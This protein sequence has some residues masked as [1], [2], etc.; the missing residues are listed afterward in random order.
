LFW[1]LGVA[2]MVV[3]AAV[4]I[5][6]G[7]YAFT[8]IRTFHHDR[9]FAELKQ[10]TDLARSSLVDVVTDD[11]SA[12]L[13]GAVATNARAA[14][15]R[16][17]VVRADGYVLADSERDPGSMDDHRNRPEIDAALRRGTGSAVRHSDTLG[18]DMLYVARRLDD[19]EPP[20]AVVRIARPRQAV[21]A[22]L[23]GLLRGVGLAGVLSLTLTLLVIILVSRSVTRTVA[24]VAEGA[25]RVAGGDLEHR[26]ERPRTREL[27]VLVDALNRLT[28]QF[29]EQIT[30][31]DTQ[32]AEQR[33]ILQSMSNGMIALD[34]D[35]RVLTVNRVAARLLGLAADPARGRL[36]QE[37][38]REPELNRFVERALKA[39]APTRDELALTSGT[40]RLIEAASEPLLDAD[41][42][43]IG[44]VILINDVTQL[45]R[46]ESMRSDFA[47]NV[48][49]ELRT[50]ITNIKGYVE[51]MLEVGFE[52]AP[53]AR[54][55]LEV[56]GRNTERLAAII[57][58]LLSLAR[59]EQPD[60]VGQIERSEVP[61][62]TVFD[63]VM[64][65]FESLARSRQIT[66]ECHAETGLRARGAPQLL[67]QAVGN[68]VSNAV[69]YSAEG[70]TVRLAA[71]RRT[72]EA[73]EITVSDQGPGIASRHLP[74]LFERF[75]R[76]DR[77]RSRAVGGTGLGLAI[78]KHIALSHGGHVEVESTVG[79]GSM[80]RIVLPHPDAAPADAATSP[81]WTRA[82]G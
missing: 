1:Q 80:F 29:A 33:A 47:A 24:R 71:R 22:A 41:E 36:L 68:L 8:T 28:G 20:R 78:V 12:T 74:R 70:T 43:P 27:G 49:H 19:T 31:L 9:T 30:Q 37:V 3:Q 25:A 23:A 6:L 48:S 45:R 39:E 44:L 59:L 54:G 21:D 46:L 7:S 2:L 51:T 61:L 50:P 14:G 42:Q 69:N 32:R 57:E 17:T 79:V 58:D 65:Q 81:D 40:E 26:F 73:I 66:L 53:R 67:A 52:D 56:I 10:L 72:A 4:A 16:V 62:T 75:Y 13:T 76:V 60:P 5:A 77:A 18:L 35:Q 11:R 63:L 15:A 34:L 55:F 82:R 64:G 38:T